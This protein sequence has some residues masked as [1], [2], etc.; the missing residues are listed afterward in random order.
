M[1]LWSSTS[2][3]KNYVRPPSNPTVLVK[4]YIPEFTTRFVLQHARSKFMSPS[5]RA[6]AYMVPSPPYG[7]TA[8]PLLII[9]AQSLKF[10]ESHSMESDGR[11]SLNQEKI[12]YVLYTCFLK[13][14]N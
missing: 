12:M 11:L 10:H 8:S 13:N 1:T 2:S 7:F 14:C 3:S 4:A 9:I 6:R 5:K